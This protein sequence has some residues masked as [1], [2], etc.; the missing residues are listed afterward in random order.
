M[1][2]DLNHFTTDP[3]YCTI[4]MTYVWATSYPAVANNRIDNVPN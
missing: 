4:W 1:V 3:A 2:I